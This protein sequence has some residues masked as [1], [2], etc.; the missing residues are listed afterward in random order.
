MEIST[1][2]R[3]VSALRTDR[4]LTPFVARVPFATT[5]LVKLSTNR[6][7]RNPSPFEFKKGQV[8]EFGGSDATRTR[9]LLRELCQA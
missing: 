4:E 8:E 1:N 3:A 2:T 6:L 7:E 9:G 5:S